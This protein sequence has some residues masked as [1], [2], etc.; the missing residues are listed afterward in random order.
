MSGHWWVRHMLMWLQAYL[1]CDAVES[2]RDEPMCCDRHVARELNVAGARQ[3]RDEADAV[4]PKEGELD[5]VERYDP[6]MNQ[7]EGMESIGEA[8]T[9][10]AGAFVWS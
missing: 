8:V 7:W 1:E 4:G 9:F 10:S 6:R 2:V 5:L 3:E